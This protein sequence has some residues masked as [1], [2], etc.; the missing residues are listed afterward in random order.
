MSQ[1]VAYKTQTNSAELPFL[2]RAIWFLAIG[3]EL[4]F[5]WILV[6]WAFNVTV[7]GLPVGLWMI[8]RIPQVLTLKARS[9]SYLVDSHGQSR[10]VKTRQVNF[11]VRALYFVLIGWWA[12]LIWALVAYLLC[13]TIVGLPFGYLMLTS[14]PFVTTLSNG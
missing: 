13:A 5:V 2:V 11:L 9:G 4:T 6:A 12:S 10:F 1:S 7:I 14:L 8:E 3:W